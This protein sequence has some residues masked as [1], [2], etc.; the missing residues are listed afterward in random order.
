M[1]NPY[2]KPIAFPVPFHWQDEVKPG[3][4]RDV[5]LGVIEPVPILCAKKDG[6]ARQTVD[7][8][9]LNLHAACET[10]RTLSLFHQARSVPQNTKKA[11]LDAWNG[12]HSVPLHEDDW[13][14]TSFITH[15]GRY[16]Y[17]IALQDYI[18][19]GDGYIWRYDEIVPDIPRK[20]K[21]V[22]DCLLTQYQR[23]C[24][25]P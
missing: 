5:R 20:T 15:W 14:L 23:A 22:D 17:C 13:H 19:S 2:A 25:R 18:A 6:T 16:Q 9:E 11:V 1:V 8:Q 7:L 4:D 3:L 24:D 21:C 10:H 12:Y